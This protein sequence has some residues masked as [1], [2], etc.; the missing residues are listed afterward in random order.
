MVRPFVIIDMQPDFFDYLDGYIDSHVM[1]FVRRLSSE[2]VTRAKNGQPVVLVEYEL[3][4]PTFSEIVRPLSKVTDIVKVIKLDDDGGDYCNIKFKRLH[5]NVD[6]I[7]I[8]G[9]NWDYCVAETLQTFSRDYKCFAISEFI[10]NAQIRP[11]AK[12]GHSLFHPPKGN[13]LAS[14][15]AHKPIS[16]FK[17]WSRKIE[18]ESRNIEVI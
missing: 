10:T 14:L 5:W 13:I 1:P 18:F 9:I 4:E 12:N 3:G 17:G 15:D 7:D 6:S 16:K 8:V 2:A 11:S